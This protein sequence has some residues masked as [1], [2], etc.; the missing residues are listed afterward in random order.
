M[1]KSKRWRVRVRRAIEDWVDVK[2]DDALQA[3][4]LAANLPQVI[5]VFD[6]SA[7]PGD[8]PVD[9]VPLAGVMEDEDD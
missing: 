7:I 9:Q 1:L 5:S 8:R 6:K 2:A 4:Q 3:E